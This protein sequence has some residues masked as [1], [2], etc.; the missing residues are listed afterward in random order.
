MIRVQTKR[1]VR[2]IYVMRCGYC[3]VTET[4][5]GAELTY[6]HFQ[7]QSKDG[8]DD[9]ENIVYACH[10][11]NEFKG[12][13]FDNADDTRLLHPLNDDLTL[14]VR[15]EATGIL[16]GTTPLGELYIR[17]LQLNRSP[18][19]LRRRNEARAEVA[20]Q[21]DEVINARL[22]AIMERVDR[23]EERLRTRSRPS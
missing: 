2:S 23:I 16:Q 14:H 10:A 3:G 17:I 5:A 6:D 22:D 21:R 11:C 7:P 1:I 9:A 20:I 19:V 12:E 18:L 15:S 4:E 8:T 13:Y